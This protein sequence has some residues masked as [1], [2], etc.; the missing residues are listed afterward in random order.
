MRNS[1]YARYGYR[2]KRDDLFKHFSQ[3]SWYH[4]TTNDMTTIYNSMSEIEKYN[5]E[6]IKNKE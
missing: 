4:P 1:I 2:F 6:I 3:Y 5:V